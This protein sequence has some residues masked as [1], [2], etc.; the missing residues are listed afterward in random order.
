MDKK[1]SIILSTYNEATIIK[2]TVNEIF[3]NLQNSEIILVDDNSE[4]G[5]L[6]KLEDIHNKDLKIFLGTQE[7]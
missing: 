5:T 4:D 1:I 6:E 2:K 3:K 7:D